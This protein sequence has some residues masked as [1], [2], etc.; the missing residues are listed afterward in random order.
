MVMKQRQS[1]RFNRFELEEINEEKFPVPSIKTGREFYR[2]AAVL[3]RRL[4]CTRILTMLH[5]LNPSSPR[6]LMFY[7]YRYYYCS[8]CHKVSG[9]FCD[10][11]FII[12]CEC[13]NQLE[14]VVVPIIKETC[15]KCKEERIID[16]I[17]FIGRCRCGVWDYLAATLH[18]LQDLLRS[19]RASAVI[20]EIVEMLYNFNMPR[21]KQHDDI[22]EGMV[23][24]VVEK[25][26]TGEENAPAPSL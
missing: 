11:K 24:E 22:E 4:F 13:G 5:N 17:T 21:M 23:G 8:N 19:D 15:P 16:P 20:S 2:W 1:L 14:A 25:N 9:K 7:H 3:R 18:G 12:H 26:K 6:S 10:G